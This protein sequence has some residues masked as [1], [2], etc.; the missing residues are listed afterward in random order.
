MPLDRTIYVK[1]GDTRPIRVQVEVESDGI[2]V[3]AATDP[4]QVTSVRFRMRRNDAPGT[5]IVDAA[6]VLDVAT[7][8]SCVLL[9]AP[10]AADFN[11]ADTYDVEWQI[12]YATGKVQTLPAQGY[13]RLVVTPRIG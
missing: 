3:P 6:A 4:S 8:T 10:Q 9:Y 11:V 2:F 12:T 5:V 13:M 1:Q 7:S